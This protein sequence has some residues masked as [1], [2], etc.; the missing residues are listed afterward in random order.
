MFD[1]FR[2]LGLQY[3]Q[4]I[5]LREA[6]KFL[7]MQQGLQDYDMAGLTFAVNAVKVLEYEANGIDLN[8]PTKM[9]Q[10]HPNICV[11]FN[12]YIRKL[13]KED[14]NHPAIPNISPGYMVWLHTL[15]SIKN[16]EARVIVKDIWKNLERGMDDTLLCTVENYFREE[17]Y[18]TIH[19]F[20]LNEAKFVPWE[21]RS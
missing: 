20:D 18:V 21:F 19:N 5:Q 1:Y 8:Q 10:L 15:R 16:L 12:S 4:S 3:F 7:K 14:V 11:N 9:V 13:Q 2:N 17:L 6:R